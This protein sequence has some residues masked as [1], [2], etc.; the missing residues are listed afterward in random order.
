M[1]SRN[2]INSLDSIHHSDR[3]QAGF[4]AFF[5]KSR[6]KIEYLGDGTQSHIFTPEQTYTYYANGKAIFSFTRRYLRLR[7]RNDGSDVA[8]NCRA[9]LKLIST[10]DTR[11]LIWDGL[12][13]LSDLSKKQSIDIEDDR[14]LHVVFSDSR[15]VEP[16]VKEHSALECISTMES[17]TNQTIFRGEDCFSL[18]DHEIEILI[19]SAKADY[20]KSRIHIKSDSNFHNL[21]MDIISQQS[22]NLKLERYKTK[23]KQFLEKTHLWKKN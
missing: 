1:G 11:E 23:F 5:T 6:L 22:G 19:K 7:V 20:C 15:F 21:N 17:I 4:E 16:P 12:T 2:S 18:R 8:N 3:R 13:V 14:L 10:G 9:V